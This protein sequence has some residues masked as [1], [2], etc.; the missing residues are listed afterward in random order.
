MNELAAALEATAIAQHLKASRWTYPLVNAGHVLGLALL[1]GAVV[2]MDLRLLR[3]TR[4]GLL[5]DVVGLLR[6]AAAAGA[7]L[8]IGCGALLF[9]AQ[10]TDYI[11]NGWFQA[12]MAL[13]AL[14]LINAAL[15]PGLAVL[16]PARQVLA[17]T[18]S[19]A[20]WPAVLLCGRMIGYS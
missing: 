13:L 5:D 15:H 10:A 2:P 4:R 18:L 14:A 12:K 7:V 8:A 3:L 20:L 19:L 11:A 1:I 6:P 16:P 17:A 9:L